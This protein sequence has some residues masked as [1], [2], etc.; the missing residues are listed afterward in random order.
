MPAQ[1]PKTDTSTFA[2]VVPWLFVNKCALGTVSRHDFFEEAEGK[3]PTYFSFFFALIY[4]EKEY[5]QRR[6]KPKEREESTL[7]VIL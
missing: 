5:L 2:T 6:H 7:R 1:C 4:T 3:V